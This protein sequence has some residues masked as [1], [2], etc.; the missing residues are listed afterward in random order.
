MSSKGQISLMFLNLLS[1]APHCGKNP[2]RAF[3]IINPRVRATIATDALSVEIVLAF[4]WIDR[5]VMRLFD[6]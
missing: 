1:K 4:D 3:L 6:L 2:P 5:L